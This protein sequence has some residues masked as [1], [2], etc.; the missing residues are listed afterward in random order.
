MGSLRQSRPSSRSIAFR[1]AAIVA[2]CGIPTLAGC[3]SST[4][5]P[6]PVTIDLQPTDNINPDNLGQ[7]API[8]VRLYF[9]QKKDTFTSSEF[10]ALYLHDKQTLAADIVSTQEFELQPGKNK[11]FNTPD[12][13]TATA[14]GIVAAYRDITNAQWRDVIDLKPHENN[15]FIATIKLGAVSLAQKPSGGWF[16]WL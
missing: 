4:P 11:T 7:A 14:V 10:N 12:A 9:L 2:I 15:E 5:D 13:Q 1:L 3:G 8:V 6:T 16:S